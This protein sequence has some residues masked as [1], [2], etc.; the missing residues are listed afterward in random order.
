MHG[1]GFSDGHVLD[2]D[3]QLSRYMPAIV[4]YLGDEI[5]PGAV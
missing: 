1:R 4:E 3:L 2:F 5:L